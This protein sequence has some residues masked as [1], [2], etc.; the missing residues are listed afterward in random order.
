MEAEQVTEV[1]QNKN[2]VWK[3]LH[4]YSLQIL[5]NFIKEN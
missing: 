5:K 1:E 4:F 3:Y 2:E